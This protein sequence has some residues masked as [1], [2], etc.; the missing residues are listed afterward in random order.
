MNRK[1]IS[2]GMSERMNEMMNERMNEKSNH[3]TPDLKVSLKI[4]VPKFAYPQDLEEAVRDETLCRPHD[5]L[6]DNGIV[7]PAY[8]GADPVVDDNVVRCHNDILINNQVPIDDLSD[9]ALLLGS[10]FNS[11]DGGLPKKTDICC[12]WDANQFE[13]PPISAPMSYNSND[14]SFCGHGCFCGFPC[15]LAWLQD[16][17]ARQ[18]YIPL[19]RFMRQKQSDV[20]VTDPLLPAPPRELLKMFGGSL[21]IEQFR[22][23]PFST[24]VGKC[25]TVHVSNMHPLKIQVQDRDVPVVESSRILQLLRS[26]RSQMTNNKPVR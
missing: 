26:K 4:N 23:D 13:T 12:W 5:P 3:V 24:G 17:P 20:L 6:A 18:K 1:G 11:S 8:Y 25:R 22:N 14:D 7:L 2:E 21:S 19:L 9:P 10:F 15:A 16:H